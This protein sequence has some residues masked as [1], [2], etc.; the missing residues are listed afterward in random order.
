[1][2]GV[3]SPKH[4][5]EFTV[6]EE[7]CAVPLWTFLEN[8]KPAGF[9]TWEQAA[10]TCLANPQ[11]LLV[12]A[13]LAGRMTDG[14]NLD[15]INVGYDNTAALCVFDGNHRTLAHAC[16]GQKTITY[17]D[18]E[19]AVEE[20]QTV[21]FVVS[22]H[23]TDDDDTDSIVD[24]VRSIP[25]SDG[26]MT[27]LFGSNRTTTDGQTIHLTYELLNTSRGLAAQTLNKNLKPLGLTATAEH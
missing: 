13:E 5:A 20:Y 14:I 27:L 19:A 10:N 21:S 18:K 2:C 4:L 23:I 11:C 1:M 17:W 25:T 16:A 7:L 26:W 22:T 8:V 12:I 24:T 3:Q 6:G 9:Q 15:P